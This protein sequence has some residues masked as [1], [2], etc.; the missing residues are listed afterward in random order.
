MKHKY[1]RYHNYGFILWPMTDLLTHA[2]LSG[3]VMGEMYVRP[4][5]AGFVSFYKGIPTCHGRSESMSLD[6]LPEDSTDLAE[7]MGIS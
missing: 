6:S 5:S 4:I 7:Q 1:V 3:L 2:T